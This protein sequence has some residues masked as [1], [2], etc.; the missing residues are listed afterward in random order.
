MSQ[1]SG[2]VVIGVKGMCGADPSDN[3]DEMDDYIEAQLDKKKDKKGGD[4]GSGGS[5]A[6]AQ[7]EVSGETA[8]DIPGGAQLAMKETK[9][10]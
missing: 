10:D 1:R 5:G 3:N 4:S 7:R 8:E 9:L 6:T 2:C